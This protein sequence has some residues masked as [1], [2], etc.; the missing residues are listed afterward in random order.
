V[1][2]AQLEKQGLAFDEENELDYSVLESLVFKPPDWLRQAGW[3]GGR[4]REEHWKKLMSSTTARVDF[5]EVA[6]LTVELI[7]QTR[8]PAQAIYGELSPCLPSL[9]GLRE[10]LPNLKS[11]ILPGLGHFFPITKP[12]LFVE[13]VKGF[14]CASSPRAEISEAADPPPSADRTRETREPPKS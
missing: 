8:V 1:W 11:V 13:H 10:C 3:I 14:H 2:K 9:V 5:K 6:G 12:A 7:A 4:R